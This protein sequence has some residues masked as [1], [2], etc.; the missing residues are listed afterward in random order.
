M[1]DPRGRTWIVKLD[2]GRVVTVGAGVD[3]DRGVWLLSSSNLLR[4]LTPDDADRIAAAL[5]DAGKH[6]DA[7]QA[8][9]K[10]PRRRR[11]RP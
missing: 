11:G 3:E 8:V 2:D 1:S 10:K 6:L 9:A 5:V 7:N 4:W